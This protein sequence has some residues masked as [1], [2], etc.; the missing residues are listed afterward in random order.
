MKRHNNLFPQVIEFSNLIIAANKALKGKKTRMRVAHFYFH[1]EKELLTLQNEVLEG[2]Y[3]PN[4]YFLFEIFDPK[5]R[6]ICASD[7]KDRVLHHAICKVL[8]PFLERKAIFDSYACRS[9]KGLHAAIK[10]CQE[11]V[12]HN[13]YY[14]KCDISRFFESIDHQIL[15]K[16]LY[17]ILKDKQLLKLLD[18]I[19]DHEVP[20]NLPGKG[21]PIGNLTSQYFANLYLGKMDHFLKD[22]LGHKSYLRYMD[23]FI[24]FAPDKQ[25]LKNRLHQIHE[26]LDSH[27]QLNLKT[28]AIH[29][30]PVSEGVPY[31]GLRVFKNLIRIQRPNL[32]RLRRRIRDAESDYLLGK[33]TLAELC[34]STSSRMTHM[35]FANTLALRQKEFSGSLLLA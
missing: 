12:G 13:E 18:V 7:F 9:G 16:I 3:K 19:I 20:G 33:L 22:H 35:S 24:L 8:E 27:L 10:R 4:H 29:L 1:W 28:N 17:G 21:L 30:A 25:I 2:T 5:K 15:K 23:D 32:V 34:Q 26:F 14:L 6:T 11:F 31:L